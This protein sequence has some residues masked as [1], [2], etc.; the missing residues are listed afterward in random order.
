[1][2]A[3]RHPDLVSA[4]VSN[5]PYLS[6]RGQLMRAVRER[7][8]GKVALMLSTAVVDKV[9][10]WRCTQQADIVQTFSVQ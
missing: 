10:T 6:A 1:M 9:R 7:G 8:L 2:M 5:E 3:A 4:V